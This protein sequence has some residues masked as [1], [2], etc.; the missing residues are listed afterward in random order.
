MKNEKFYDLHADLCKAISN[1]R[2]QAIIDTIRD[3]ELTVNE[4]V[5]I[6]GIAQANL[7]QHLTILRAKGVVHTRREGNKVF[8]SLSNSKIIKA[9]DLISEVLRET[10]V[11]QNKIAKK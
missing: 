1:P 3:D 11:S 4:M 7:S 6:T 2:R 5:K 10:I 8:Y 9:Y